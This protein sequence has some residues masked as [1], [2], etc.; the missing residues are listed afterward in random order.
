M[1]KF[2]QLLNNL[3]ESKT[4]LKL[5]K[6]IQIFFANVPGHSLNDKLERAGLGKPDFMK[7]LNKMTGEIKSSKIESGVYGFDYVDHGFKIPVDYDHTVKHAVIKTIL[8]KEMPLK[9][10][11]KIFKIKK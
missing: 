4:K 3:F 2:S 11:D 9:D 6:N 10:C 5:N 7:H 8:S 1:K